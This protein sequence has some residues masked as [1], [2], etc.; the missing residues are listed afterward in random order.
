MGRVLVS[1]NL[2]PHERPDFGKE[3]LT[4]S[5]E[6]DREN[7]C[8][9]V[10]IIELQLSTGDEE[11]WVE[12]KFGANIEKSKKSK[13]RNS[14]GNKSSKFKNFRFKGSKGIIKEIKGIFPIEKSQV[15]DIFLN[16]YVDKFM[17]KKY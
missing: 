4:G 2:I 11:C 8:L 17:S 12:V 7:Y 9:R 13:F 5:L 6:P 3:V 10:N 16:I 1:M 15:P 14:S